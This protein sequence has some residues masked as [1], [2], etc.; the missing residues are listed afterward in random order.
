MAGDGIAPK[1][2]QEPGTSK[3]T[4]GTGLGERDRPKA[5]HKQSSGQRSGP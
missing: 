5:L 2:S 1:V 4:L 3:A